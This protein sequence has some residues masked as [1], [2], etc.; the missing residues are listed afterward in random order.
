MNPSLVEQQIGAGLPGSQVVVRSDDN[1]HYEAIVI[2]PQF[3]GKRLLQR[4]QLVHGQHRAEA[5][6]AEGLS[7][8]RPVH[9]CS[10]NRDPKL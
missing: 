8:A 7:Q 2:A 4:H 10:T 5:V 3:V 1:T 6:L 9:L